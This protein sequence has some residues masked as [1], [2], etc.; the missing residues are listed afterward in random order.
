MDRSIKCILGVS[1]FLIGS[2][3][4]VIGARHNMHIYTCPSRDG[5]VQNKDSI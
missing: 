4:T 5:A 2:K 3:N 1:V